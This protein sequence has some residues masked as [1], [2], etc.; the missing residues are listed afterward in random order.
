[1]KKWGMRGS[2]DLSF[3]WVAARRAP[4]I[5]RYIS[6]TKEPDAV[7]RAGIQ[8]GIVPR[9]DSMFLT[10]YVFVPFFYWK[11]LSER[12]PGHLVGGFHRPWTVTCSQPTHGCHLGLC[13][14]SQILSL[15]QAGYKRNEHTAPFSSLLTFQ[16]MRE[17]G[18]GHSHPGV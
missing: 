4:F 15:S 13:T 6:N 1:M 5:R 17:M 14:C 9:Q 8:G 16:G 7:D 11:K 12:I 18:L 2:L 10:S 3:G